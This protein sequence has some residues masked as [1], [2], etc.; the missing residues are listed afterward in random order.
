MSFEVGEL[1]GKLGLDTKDFDSG[2]DSA[3]ARFEGFGSKLQS[4]ALSLAGAIGSVLKDAAMIGGAAIVGAATLGTK[5]FADY[6]QGLANVKKTVGYTT[7]EAKAF[8]ETLRELSKQTGLSV[9]ALEEIASTGGSIGI[10]KDSME[11]FTKSVAIGTV[12]LGVSQ[13]ELA[14]AAGKWMQVFQIQGPELTNALS[15]VN[16][17][18]NTTA[19][20]SGQLVSGFEQL[21]SIAPKMGMGFNQANAYLATQVTYLGDVEKA[22]TGLDSAFNQVLQSEENINKSASVLGVSTGQFIDMMKTDGLN[23][24]HDLYLA[25]DKAYSKEE[26]VVQKQKLFGTYGQRAMT[27]INQGWKEYTKNLQ[28]STSAFQA[29]NS[30]MKEFDTATNTTWGSINRLK[31]GLNDVGIE[32][33]QNIAPSLNKVVSYMQ[34]KFVPAAKAA[35]QAFFS[36]DWNKLGGV[37]KGAFDTAISGLKTYDWTALFSSAGAALSGAF[38]ALQSVDWSSLVSG[39]MSV[40]GQLAETVQNALSQ[41][42]WV[43][44]GSEAMQTIAAALQGLPGVLVPIGQ[45]AAQALGGAMQGAGSYIVSA[46]SN[47]DVSSVGAQMGNAILSGLQGVAGFATWAADKINGVNW[48]ALGS[49]AG[50]LLG[51]AIVSGLRNGLAAVPDI[52]AGIITLVGSS[53]AAMADTLAGGMTAALNGIMPMISQAIGSSFETMVN[54]MLSAYNY[55]GTKLYDVIGKQWE[56]IKPPSWL[57]DWK[58]SYQAISYNGEIGSKLRDSFEGFAGAVHGATAALEGLASAANGGLAAPGGNIGGQNLPPAAYSGLYTGGKYVKMEDYLLQLVQQGYNQAQISTLMADY[59]KKQNEWIQKNP[60]YRDDLVYGST[61]Q[62]SG[63]EEKIW[64]AFD[65]GLGKPLG[66]LG[67]D[68]FNNVDFSMDN[69]T[70]YTN[71]AGQHFWTVTGQSGISLAAFLTTGSTTASNKIVGAGTG[72]VNAL[73]PAAQA[74][75]ALANVMTQATQGEQKALTAREKAALADQAAHEWMATAVK[76]AANGLG[77]TIT[78]AGAQL[79]NA[80]TIF[81]TSSQG[82]AFT[83]AETTVG[84]A[85]SFANIVVAAGS[86]FAAAV[87]SAAAGGGGGGGGGV[88]SAVANQLYN[89]L[90]RVGSTGPSNYDLS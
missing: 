55:V 29:G 6:E 28:T 53:L 52:L 33:G 17:L 57:D 16:E 83:A 10:A 7:E 81:G 1:Y 51:N 15:A 23:T 77:A 87:G 89:A 80:G 45:A 41:V 40:A 61:N 8:G 78:S 9:T 56:D 48:S 85:T 63:M 35:V 62:F 70:Q 12:A 49:S 13:E 47:I 36:G 74:Q 22:A 71:D 38:A 21:A 69:F 19:A 75:S 27:A 44:V 34:D 31:A 82:A 58:D 11:D 43:A 24:M 54:G 88:S 76:N 37:I 5:A 86:A 66:L 50:S 79:T 32:I 60:G 68:W 46:L 2:L 26:A 39:F 73:A 65:Q 72:F 30:V 20:K 4:S 90:Q 3:G 25:I 64:T 67:E 42:N 18:E 14:T 59:Q 84:S